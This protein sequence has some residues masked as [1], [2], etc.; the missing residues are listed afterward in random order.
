MTKVPL[1]L[2]R[3]LFVGLLFLMAILPAL[4]WNLSSL[5][6]LQVSPKENRREG[7]YKRL[8]KGPPL[9]RDIFALPLI[10]L[11]K[12]KFLGKRPFE[13]I[14]KDPYP[15]EL[16]YIPSLL[17]LAGRKQRGM[18]RRFFFAMAYLLGIKQ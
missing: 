2:L 4:L 8:S 1:S 14:V 9:F 12:M 7:K 5:P 15:F 17:P 18:F 13:V 6:S 11:G 10:A 16:N 3:Y